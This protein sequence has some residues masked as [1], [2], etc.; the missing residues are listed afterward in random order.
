MLA[1]LNINEERLLNYI[2][3]DHVKTALKLLHLDQQKFMYVV[4]NLD[5]IF[6]FVDLNLSY[7]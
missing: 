5:K 2:H 4:Q 3:T 6:T 1:Y 7:K